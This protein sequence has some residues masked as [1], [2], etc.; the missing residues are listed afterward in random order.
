[1][2]VIMASMCWWLCWCVDVLTALISCWYDDY[3]GGGNELLS[4]CVW[5]C[6]GIALMCWGARWWL[7][8]CVDDTVIPR[9]K[10]LPTV[11]ATRLDLTL[12]PSTPGTFV[13]FYGEI[14]GNWLKPKLSPPGTLNTRNYCSDDALMTCW[15]VDDCVDDWPCRWLC[16]CVMCGCVS[17]LCVRVDVWMCWWLCWWRVG[18]DNYVLWW[19]WW[20]CWCWWLR[21]CVF[22]LMCWWL[23]WCCVLM[24]CVV[25]ST[26]HNYSHQ[27]INT[28]RKKAF[29]HGKFPCKKYGF[30][31]TCL[32]DVLDKKNTFPH[33]SDLFRHW[34]DIL[35]LLFLSAPN[36]WG[37]KR[38]SSTNIILF[39][40]MA[41]FSWF[42]WRL[43][44]FDCRI[45]KID[46]HAF[47]QSHIRYFWWVFSNFWVL[48]HPSLSCF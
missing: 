29:P 15:G 27:R 46:F 4:W 43:F 33:V 11:Y 21:C 12:K 41:R 38:S 14:W 5:W 31:R 9:A 34:T 30:G 19:Y 7:C 17:V 25:I 47:F 20:L 42:F 39:E 44:K 18:F 48:I 24:C 40:T 37:P 3:C 22:L 13:L 26:T 6:V 36:F 45:G 28:L 16:W 35:K 10:G 8:W 2:C 23:C 1:M 32:E